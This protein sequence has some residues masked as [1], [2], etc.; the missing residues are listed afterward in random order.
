[1]DPFVFL[2]LFELRRTNTE[3]KVAGEIELWYSPTQAQ[4]KTL[5]TTN[6]G[7]TVYWLCLVDIMDVNGT[8]KN[9][10]HNREKHIK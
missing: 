9:Q 2:L 5:H 3:Q 10:R 4:K 6:N 1:M 8:Q 7:K